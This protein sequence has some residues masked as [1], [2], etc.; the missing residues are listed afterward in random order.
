MYPFVVSTNGLL[1]DRASPALQYKLVSDNHRVSSESVLPDRAKLQKF[2]TPKFKP[3]TVKYV[4]EV[5][6]VFEV[7]SVLAY[8]KLYVKRMDTLETPPG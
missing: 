3:W 7:T 6:G 2:S 4:D 8:A 5:M 1:Q